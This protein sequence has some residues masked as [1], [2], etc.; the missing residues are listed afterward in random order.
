MNT[1]IN[2]LVDI[3]NEYTK[4]L[5]NMLSPCIYE[6]FKSIYVDGKKIKNNQNILKTFQ[7]II[8]QIPKWNNSLIETESIR[9]KNKC[10]CEWLDDLVK[11]VV[12]SNTKILSNANSNTVKEMVGGNNI[13]FNKFIHK[14]YIESARE[15]YKNP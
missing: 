2:A 13:D 10:N 7:T 8:G 1:N 6:G 12:I 3:K 4:Q 15:F 11:A 14:C 9:I 5:V